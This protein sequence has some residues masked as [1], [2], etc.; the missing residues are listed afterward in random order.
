MYNKIFGHIECICKVFLLSLFQLSDHETNDLFKIH[1]PVAIGQAFTLDYG[2]QTRHL[3]A[4][5]FSQAFCLTD[6]VS[7]RVFMLA[8]V[9]IFLEF[10]LS[11]I[12]I[13]SGDRDTHVCTARSRSSLVYDLIWE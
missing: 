7:N 4:L 8:L 9:A 6:L 12:D 2:I 11:L 3:G 10:T 13:Q 5:H 1:S